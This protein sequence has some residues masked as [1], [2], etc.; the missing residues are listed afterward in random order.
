MSRKAKTINSDQEEMSLEDH[1]GLV[2]ARVSSK[3]QEIEGTGLESQETRCKREL[4][5]QRVPYGKSFLDSYTGQGDFMKRPA[6]KEMLSYIDKNPHQKFLVVFDDLKRFARDVEFHLKLRAAFKARSVKLRC[7]NYNFDDT[8]E[9]RFSEVVMA[10]QAALEREQNK[11]QVIQKMKARLESGLWPF[12]G[13]KGYNRNPATKNMEPNTEG[14]DMLKPAME[15]F[16]S[17]ILPRKIDVCKFLVEKRFWQKQNPEKYIDKLADILKDP[18]YAGDIMYLPWGVERRKG[19]HVGI[20]SHET[21]DSVQKRLASSSLNK[22]IRTDI[23][24]K[25]P[26]RGLLVCAG[27]DSHL[28]AAIVNPNT[29]PYSYY[30]CQHKKCSL[31]GKMALKKNVEDA[32]LKILE[33]NKLKSEVGKL[34]REIFARVWDDEIKNLAKSDRE[35]QTR[36][37]GLGK[38]AADL[39]DMVIAAKS[40]SLRGLYEKQLES[41]ATELEIAEKEQSDP[42]KDLDVPYR[43]AIE[44]ATALVENPHSVW[45]S[46][47]TRE[48]HRLFFFLFEKKLAYSRIEGYRNAKNTSAVRLFEEFAD[49]NPHHVEMGGIEPPSRRENIYLSTR[50]RSFKRFKHYAYG[51]NKIA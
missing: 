17:G 24:D 22:R 8:P 40:P 20:I 9:G 44:K 6:M 37:K 23:T 43:A 30:Y 31:Y 19:S 50:R 49:A 33:D 46:L 15:M 35:Q 28:T 3:R 12:G 21:Y 4:E 11:R 26:L 32:F 29:K 48:Q 25:F 38:K 42:R 10:G 27:C 14:L 45:K 41:V 39:T 16:A 13:K 36:L 18:F 2:Y 34:V 5:S 47:D 51:M 1:V 7:L